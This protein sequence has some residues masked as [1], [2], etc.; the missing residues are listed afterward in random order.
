MRA[1]GSEG[2]TSRRRND[3]RP[4]SRFTTTSCWRVPVASLIVFGA[5]AAPASADVGS[6]QLKITKLLSKAAVTAA[7]LTGGCAVQEASQVF[8]PWADLSYYTLAPQGDFEG[9]TSWTLGS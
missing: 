7:G 1:L 6:T 4:M 2:R 8:A 3:P 5:I 9:P